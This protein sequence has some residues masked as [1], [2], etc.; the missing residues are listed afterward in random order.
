MGNA[1]KFTETGEIELKV[2]ITEKKENKIK[3]YV[4]VKDTGIGIPENKLNTIFEHFQQADGSTTRKYG[5]TGLGLSICKQLAKLMGGDVWVESEEGKG[6]VFHFSAWV[7]TSEKKVEKKPP[8]E[9]LIG[10]RAVIVDDNVNN[11]DILENILNKY[12]MKA[13]PLTRSDQ[14]IETI[15]N[16]IAQNRDIHICILDIQM[17]DLSGYDLAKKVRQHENKQISEMPLLA[18]SSSTTKRTR[19]YRE[20]GFDGFL[21]KPIQRQKLVTMIKRLLGEKIESDDKGDKKMVI[22]QH[23]IV[24]DAKHSIR[25]LLAE[26]NLL[27]QKLAKFMLTKAGYQLEVCLLYTSPSPRDRTRS[28]MPSSA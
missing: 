9:M 10:K 1:V 3:L 8:T 23:S 17:P 4:S 19:M 22:T 11:L 12:G 26:D 18:F 15:E 20:S 7:E 16:E 6:T 27:N 5:G 14:M 21:P 25:I 13:I 28:R 2:D 24:E